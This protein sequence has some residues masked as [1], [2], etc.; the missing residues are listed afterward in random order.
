MVCHMRTQLIA[1]FF[2]LVLVALF[3]WRLP[4]VLAAIPGVEMKPT[5][6][7]GIEILVDPALHDVNSSTELYFPIISIDNSP[8]GSLADGW[9]LMI[10]DGHIAYRDVERV[11]HPFEKYA[12]NPI[13]VADR[14]WEGRAIQL[15]GTVLPGFRMWYSSFN[16][17]WDLHQVL[18]ADS[19]D[20][21][22]WNKPNLNNRGDNALLGGVNAGNVS[23]LNTP[24]DLD[25]TYKLM[26]FQNPAF[27]GYWSTS[28]TD[29]TPY[30][31]DPLFQNGNDV[32]HFYWDSRLQRYGGTAK[33]KALVAGVYRRS[34]RFLYSDDFIYWALHPNLLTPDAIDDQLNTGFYT[35]L[36]GLPVFLM[37]EQY[38]GLLWVFRA[39]DISGL[40][41]KVDVQLVSSH[42]GINWIRE[43]GGRPAIL[44]L[45]RKGEWDR[46]QIYTS[47]QP[48]RVGDELWLYYSGCN[49]EH[50]S[51]L[52]DTVC[53][54]GL[55]K[56]DY[57]RLA[58]LTG[59]GTVLTSNLE[60]VGEVLYLNYNARSGSIRVELLRDGAVI[61][62]YEANNCTPLT[63]K[64]LIQPVSWSGQNGLPETPY[65]V[66]FYLEN[67]SLF[68]FLIK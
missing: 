60:V 13:M 58:S 61:P 23:L 12:G 22:S 10:D 50:G 54:I 30:P 65:Q 47:L 27:W 43:D 31:E 45:G 20:G 53:S 62:G 25:K 51:S 5:I 38:V 2:I 63:G 26:A 34:V 49:L 40:T 29:F 56:V 4:S 48:I 36:Y 67:S 35:H 66:K 55:S 1:R 68:A 16:K 33:E 37:G 41:G 7:R 42:D 44:E 59:S 46:G 39:R 8:L 57:D 64:S 17:E 15:H 6:S 32:A 52:Y 18:Y 3:F 9:F 28:G 19:S 21:I 11:Y 24:L 14:P